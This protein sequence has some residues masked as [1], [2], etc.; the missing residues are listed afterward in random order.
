[1]TTPR[2]RHPH[3]G[4]TARFIESLA[5]PNRFTALRRALFSRLPFPALRSDVFDVVYLT[6][7][8]P[9]A[10]AGA[11]APSSIELW[12]QDGFTPFT[13]LSY[14]HRHFGP[15][16]LGPLR[17]LC[18]SPLQSNWRLYL[19]AP[20]AGSPHPAQKTVLFTHNV[21][22]SL[23]HVLGARL[24]SDALP[25]HLPARFAHDAS[26]GFW[27]TCIDP[28]NGSSPL[29]KAD[30]RAVAEPVLPSAFE[31]FFGDWPR[32]VASLTL[33]EAA[34]VEVAGTSRLA[35]AEIELPVDLDQVRPALL[36]HDSF[37]CP[38]VERLQPVAEPLCFIVPRVPFKV[39]SETL[40]PEVSAEPSD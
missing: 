14:A 4:N 7:L 5:N 3:R 27:R 24:F 25:A 29:L 30:V 10:H 33:Q 17:R 13:I 40:L 11:L 37:H 1:M 21:L 16:L 15:A 23:A 9:V 31:A 36:E 22:D 32:A 19:G 34:M 39:C 28:G 38:V 20:P 18:P 26:D 35:L 6:W 2:Y 12:Q 8:V